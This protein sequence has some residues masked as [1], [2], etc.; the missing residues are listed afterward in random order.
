MTCA[1]ARK[2]LALYAGGDL[3]EEKAREISRHV[4]GCP[5]CRALERELARSVGWLRLGSTPPVAETEYAELRRQVWKRIEAGG[6]KSSPAPVGRA[7]MTLAAAG[8]LAA[9]AAALLLTGRPRES[10]LASAPPVAPPASTVAAEPAVVAQTVSPA[11]DAPIAVAAAVPR[12]H[13]R[14]SRLSPET[15][16]AVDRIEF[17]TANP[18]VRI[19]WLVKKG[20]EKSSALDAG[21][22][23]EVS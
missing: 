22:N 21:R 1:R 4:E 12:Q 13:A 9:A 14:R 5:D 8:V 10:R 15:N 11:P 16:S 20:E 23:Q 17:R 18:N 19:I 2:L 6:R 7:R 3:S